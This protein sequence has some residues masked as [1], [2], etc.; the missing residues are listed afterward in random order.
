MLCSYAFSYLSTFYR[1]DH[2]ISALN[3]SATVIVM[4]VTLIAEDEPSIM[5]TRLFLYL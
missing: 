2:L 3:P 5:L 1:M 4:T